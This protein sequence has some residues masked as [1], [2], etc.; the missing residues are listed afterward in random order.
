M[1]S[2]L[3]Q[4]KRENTPGLL[5]CSLVFLIYLP[6]VASWSVSCSHAWT[7]VCKSTCQSID[8]FSQACWSQG[9]L[10][11][12]LHSVIPTFID[13]GLCIGEAR[14]LSCLPPKQTPQVG[15]HLVAPRFV[16]RVTL[17]TFLDKRRLPF[18]DVPH[19]QQLGGEE[20]MA[21]NAVMGSNTG[22][23]NVAQGTWVV[24]AKLPSNF[25]I[26]VEEV[27]QHEL[28]CTERTETFKI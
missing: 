10:H 25:R 21:I 15:A 7:A 19:D 5:M 14:R 23:H 3:I 27:M 2:I 28:L 26:V 4:D 1:S 20:R 16:H 18:G 8:H 9:V 13:V 12:L 17:G 22:R 24:K 6:V 11:E